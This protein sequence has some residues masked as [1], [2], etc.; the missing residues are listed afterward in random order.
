MQDQSQEVRIAQEEFL[1]SLFKADLASVATDKAY[2]AAILSYRALLPQDQLQLL[3]ALVNNP[4]FA[5][6]V[7][8]LRYE[9]K[10][11]EEQLYL[12][13]GDV[14]G[15]YAKEFQTG[16]MHG[17]RMLEFRV[18]ESIQLLQENVRNAK[19]D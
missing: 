19:Q 17:L 10:A 12:P 3:L 9:F 4:A 16:K 14:A 1:D 5:T 8:L 15:T 2:L 18:R 13:S 11:A 6:L 7:S